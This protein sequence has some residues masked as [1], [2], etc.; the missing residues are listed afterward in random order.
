MARAALVVREDL[1]AL[2]GTGCLRISPER[3]RVGPSFLLYSLGLDEL[4]SWL[5]LDAV[6]STLANLNEQIVGRVPIAV[7]PLREQRV[8][9][10]YLNGSLGRVHLLT[11]R[12]EA[13]IDQLQEYRTALITAAVTG[14]ID[15]RES[16]SEQPVAT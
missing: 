11:E 5:E 13:A 2:C 7:P 1:P 3:Q 8:I 14:K 15:V 16:A 12:V 4:R 9:V 6:G 10:E